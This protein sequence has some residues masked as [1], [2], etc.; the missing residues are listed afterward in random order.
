MRKLVAAFAA[1]SLLVGLAAPAEAGGRH[2]RHHHDDIDG[3]DIVAGA[4]VVGGIALLASAIGDGN[5]RKQ[6][7]AVDRCSAEAEA[8]TAGHVVEIVHVGKRKG[9]YT[10]E[11]EV[12][13]AAGGIAPFSCT[14]RNGSI[15]SFRS[16]A[17]RD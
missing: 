13:A 11:G 5:R 8:R 4:A 10:V 6:D 3:G 17:G 14:T 15:Y 12:E 7:A 1:S 2:R 9:Y 16:D